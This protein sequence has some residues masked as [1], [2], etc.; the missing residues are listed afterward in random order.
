MRQVEGYG[1][2]EGSWRSRIDVHGPRVGGS[3]RRLCLAEQF[4]L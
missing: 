1:V 2:A 3:K 4:L